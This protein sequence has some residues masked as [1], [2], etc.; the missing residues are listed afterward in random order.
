MSNSD[1]FKK[2]P[3]IPYLLPQANG[4]SEQSAMAMPP[5]AVWMPG[6]ECCSTDLFFY[7]G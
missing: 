3:D 1:L 2:I 7:G 6:Q 5:L 4:D